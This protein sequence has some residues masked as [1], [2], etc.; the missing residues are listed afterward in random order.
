MC[1]CAP[2]FNS[3]GLVHLY[4]R[5]CEVISIECQPADTA[6]VLDNPIIFLSALTPG[7]AGFGTR[8]GKEGRKEGEDPSTFR[9][10][11]KTNSVSKKGQTR[12]EE[13]FFVCFLW[14]KKTN[15][16]LKAKKSESSKSVNNRKKKEIEVSWSSF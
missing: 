11:K 5:T 12:K 9:F 14:R 7:L 10:A 16:S 15:L 2:C 6:N 8:Q 1:G 3:P 13:V 4:P